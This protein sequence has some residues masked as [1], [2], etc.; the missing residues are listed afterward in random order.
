MRGLKILDG[1]EEN[2]SI[3][4]AADVAELADAQA[5]GACGLLARGGST[6][7]IRIAFLAENQSFLPFYRI[8][9]RIIFPFFHYHC[10]ILLIQSLV[11][12]M[13]NGNGQEKRS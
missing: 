7:L 11:C 1:G 6:P 13:S 5:S 8:S 3:M 9:Y 4:F 10:I 12:N 2:D